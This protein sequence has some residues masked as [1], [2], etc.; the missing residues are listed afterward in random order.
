MNREILDKRAR[1]IM[2]IRE[3]D[4][5]DIS[6]I[7]LE[8]FRIVTKYRVNSD[9]FSKWKQLVVYLE[10]EPGKRYDPFQLNKQREDLS[11]EVAAGIEFN[12]RTYKR[13]YFYEGLDFA[14]GMT[15]MEKVKQRKGSHSNYDKIWDWAIADKSAEIGSSEVVMPKS[16]KLGECVTLMSSGL[17]NGEIDY[18]GQTHI[19]AGGVKNI[20]R[21]V[22]ETRFS[23]P[24]LNVLYIADKKIVI[25]ELISQD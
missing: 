20:V 14:E 2:V 23:R 3:D 13:L 19:V 1:V 18:N 16:P 21:K 11:V 9:E 7:L 22:T 17:I 8:K 6:D 25:K 24:F 12:P 15:R 5:L 10:Y 4:F